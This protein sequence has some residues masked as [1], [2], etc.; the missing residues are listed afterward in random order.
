MN[1]MNWTEMPFCHL[2]CHAVIICMA[3]WQLGRFSP[4]KEKQI[5]RLAIIKCCQAMPC[6]TVPRPLSGSSL[7]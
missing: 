2:L 1:A 4:V 5:G 3:N 7:F 6:S